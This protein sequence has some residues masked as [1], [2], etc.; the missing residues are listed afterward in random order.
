MNK[1]NG[2]IQS[3][4]P[5]EY[6]EGEAEGYKAVDASIRSKYSRC[7]AFVDLSRAHGELPQFE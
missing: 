1:I 3:I 4:T 5:R 2:E 6:S 7:S